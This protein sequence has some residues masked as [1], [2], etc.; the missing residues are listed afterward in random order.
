MS[1]FVD[2]SAWY[3]VVISTDPNHHLARTWLAANKER[4]LT[5]DFVIDETLTLLRSRIA[6]STAI[7]FGSQVLSS[8][9]VDVIHVSREQFME[10]WRVFRDFAETEWSFTDCTSKVVIEEL[11]IERTFSFDRHFSQFGTVRVVP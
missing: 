9:D 4:L 5:T 7:E 10:A 8:P 1:I 2:T 6:G 3:A 11:R